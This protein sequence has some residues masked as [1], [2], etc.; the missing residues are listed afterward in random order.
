AVFDRPPPS[1]LMP[2]PP[3]PQTVLYIED[4][5]VNGLLVE[6]LLTGW[7]RVNFVLAEDGVTGIA[8][9]QQHRPAVILLDLTLPDMPGREVLQRLRASG[10]TA[11]VVILSGTAVVGERQA[12]L[13]AGATSFWPKPFDL[14]SFAQGMEEL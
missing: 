5:P 8:L 10:C 9:A 2:Q 11:P 6:H 14:P 12:L 4:D 7:S 13:D 3:P 1:T